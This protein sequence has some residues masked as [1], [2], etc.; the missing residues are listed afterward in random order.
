M[1]QG[2]AE[3]KV[4]DLLRLEF[5]D[6]GEGELRMLAQQLGGLD[7]SVLSATRKDKGKDFS[8]KPGDIKNL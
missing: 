8:L 4:M 5:S 2:K 1:K 6:A 3:G 7:D